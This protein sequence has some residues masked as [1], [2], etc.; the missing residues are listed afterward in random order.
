MKTKTLLLVCLFLGLG[1]SQISAQ[2]DVSKDVQTSW[3][4]PVFCDGVMVDYIWGYCSMHLI[5]HYNK[6]EW[7][8]ETASFKATGW[9][10]LPPYEEFSVNEQDKIKISQKVGNYTW[11]WDDHLKGNKGAL[12]NISGYMIY[13]DETGWSDFFIK[14]ANCTGNSR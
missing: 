5:D 8:W 12:Y 9:S 11:N 1:L 2:S 10:V 6:G 7:Q 3:G 13:S 4:C 14:N